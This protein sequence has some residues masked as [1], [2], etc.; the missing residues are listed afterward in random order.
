MATTNRKSGT[1][2]SPIGL[3]SELSLRRLFD[4]EPCGV[5][6]FQAVQLLERMYP[7]REPVGSF[8]L[9]SRE[10]VR[11][12]V[13]NR[14]GFPAS[15]IQ[16]IE[17]PEDGPP[18]M[19]VNFL[20]LTGPSAVLPHIYTLLI[21]ERRWA[22]DRTLQ[23]FLD[24][25]HHRIIS[26]FYRAR[27][28][29]RVASGL[30][31]SEHRVTDYLKDLTGIGTP[32]LQDRQNVADQSLLYYTG[33]LGLQPRSAICF[34]HLL[35]DYFGLPAEIQQ[36]VGA[37]YDLPRYA[38]CELMDEDRAARQLGM[39]AVAGDQVWDHSSKARIRIGPVTLERY[40]EFLPGAPAY[41]ALAALARFYS[42][43]QIDFDVQLV[44]ARDEVPEYELGGEDELPLGLCSWAKTGEFEHDPDDAILSLGDEVWA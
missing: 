33:I 6:F 14:I 40:R 28:K 15:E 44:L 12:A 11:F 25:F 39:G 7:D 22:R 43:G 3:T 37:W 13:Y 31:S 29:Y 41:Q 32:G 21:V 1:G 10:V 19:S 17:W 5:E 34:E 20:G 24:I 42:G 23:D 30:A 16:S 4:R 26:F 18:I 35:Q 38:Q 27:R 36:F 2:L 9:P 8:V